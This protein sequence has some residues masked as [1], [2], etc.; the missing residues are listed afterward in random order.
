MK[1]EKIIVG[2]LKTNCYLLDIDNEV[3]IIDPGDEFEKIKKAIGNRKVIGVLLTHF[4]LDHIGALEEVL[5]QYD[6]ETNK[7]KSDKFHFEIIETPGHTT[8]SK[9]YYFPKEKIMFVGDFI[10]KDGI[11]RT[12][13]GGSDKDMLN[14]LKDIFKYPEDTILYPGHG[15]ITKLKDE[16]NNLKKYYNI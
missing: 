15:D 12:D 2:D 4:H 3:L 16:Q 10:F 9:T 5:S 8:E 14:S 6:I 11:G 1:I 13:L 7:V